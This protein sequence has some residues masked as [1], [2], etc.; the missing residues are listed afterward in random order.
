MRMFVD[1]TPEDIL[2]LNYKNKEITFEV[3]ANGI[4]RIMG[5][6]ADDYEKSLNSRFYER[7]IDKKRIDEIEKNFNHAKDTGEGFTEVIKIKT[8]HDV[9]KW[10]KLNFSFVKNDG[11]DAIY[12]CVINDITEE[13]KK[14]IE[15]GGKEAGKH[16][17]PGKNKRLGLGY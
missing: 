16:T 9:T 11:N 1:N 15:L 13:K 14:E 12:M 10:M 3:I 8:K 7:F 5:H 17:S 6:S 4:S 2:L